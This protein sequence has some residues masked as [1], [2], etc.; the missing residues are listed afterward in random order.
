M[1]GRR[2]EPIQESNNKTLQRIV[3]NAVLFKV[4]GHHG[5]YVL[6]QRCRAQAAPGELS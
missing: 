2:L 4:K 3:G 5:Y 6:Y 1:E